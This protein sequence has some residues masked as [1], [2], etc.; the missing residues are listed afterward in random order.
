MASTVE[1]HCTV[2]ISDEAQNDTKVED[3]QKQLEDPD[4]DV[5]IQALKE[6]ILM[7]VNGIPLP[8]LLMPVI[9][10]C[11]RS[12]NHTI[13]K[14]L[15]LFWE[16]AEKKQPNGK[17]LPEMILVCNALLQDLQH[18]NEYVRGR[19]LRLLCTL[20]EPEII[21]P[22]KQAITQNL[23]HRHSYVRKNAALAVFSI[24]Q[25]GPDLIPD[26]VDLIEEF[27]MEEADLSA[28][29]NAFLMLFH[30][31][32]DA[33]VNYLGTVIGE[34]GSTG[35]AF[36]MVVL[37]LIRKIFRQ[38]PVD[39]HDRMHYQKCVF[40]LLHSQSK[41]VCFEAANTIL[42]L[43]AL[44]SSARAS[45]AAVR[46][47]TEILVSESDNNVKLIILE[48]LSVLKKRHQR[49]LQNAVMDILKT[50][51]T[52]NIDIRRKTLKIALDL[53][54][55]RNIDEIIKYLKK[56]I[57]ASG[58]SDDPNTAKYK[59]ALV[60]A[61][62]KENFC[63]IRTAAVFRVALWI[64]GE[65]AEEPASLKEALK[66]IIDAMG[67]LPLV[68]KRKAVQQEA[69]DDDDKS[70]T[71]VAAAP[72]ILADGTYATQGPGDQLEAR[73]A[74]AASGSEEVTLRSLVVGGDY[75][76]ATAVANAFTKLVLRFAEFCG[77]ETAES[78]KQIA[79]GIL[80]VTSMLR[81]GMA[82][83]STKLIDAD[84]RDRMVT[85]VR[86]LLSPQTSARVFL[87]D[88]RK[89]FVEMLGGKKEAVEDEQSAAPTR[90]PDDVINI[91][92][93]RGSNY[94]EFSEDDD[95]EAGLTRAVGK[96]AG[97]ESD[98]A[99]RLNN[100][101]QL[102]G[103]SD[104]VYAEACVVVNEFD[105]VL[106]ILVINQTGKTLQNL[107]IE[108]STHGDLKVVERPQSYTLAPHDF[109]KIQAN[110]KVSSTESGIIFG[111]IV[112][113]T[114]GASTD[115]EIVI[116]N[117]IHMDVGD[118]ISPGTCT[119]SKFTD[120]WAE[121]EWENKVPVNTDIQDL[122]EYLKHIMAITNMNCLTPSNTLQGKGEFLA[123]NLFATSIFGEDAL[124]NLSVEYKSG[125]KITGYIRIRSKTQGIARSLGDKIQQQ[126]RAPPK[127][128]QC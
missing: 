109:K 6:I 43:G 25:D 87:E 39:V 60:D 11:L 63:D 53:A 111:N 83:T 58:V 110:V 119:H 55:S 41:T 34:I 127:K 7:I 47:M 29:R 96:S 126:Q 67:K 80:L 101:I 116:M 2:L 121:F 9:K 108:L 48:R 128:K 38:G 26:A 51:A 14:L 105:I 50:L 100:I 22:L 91:R 57:V 33:A 70:D 68:E 72:V 78:H 4:E 20:K 27:I 23:K 97:T 93:L 56:E 37:E 102:T 115:P 10:F 69:K 15:M 32:Q 90:Q 75:F 45:Q 65:Y 99:V 82:S 13:K 12:D 35:T 44:G 125:S 76:L 16:V 36:Q 84:S 30:C 17:L 71:F 64:L 118:Y 103:L 77:F 59:D 112:F 122:N 107:T 1:N 54:C 104:P 106:D 114:S 123:A 46:T 18:A 124:L 24:Y 98:F 40:E 95:D 79:E 3:L 5:K 19:T 88:C 113:N 66:A 42:T 85:C 62:H 28:K 117:S 81:L 61:I 86:A 89:T 92:Q 94:A 31:D 52:P 49:A 120:M 74:Q 21:E 73:Q 8:R